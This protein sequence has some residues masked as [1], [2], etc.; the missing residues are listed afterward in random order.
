MAGRTGKVAG[1]LSAVKVAGAK[2]AGLYGDGNGL[3]LKV[4]PGG[5]KSWVLRYKIRGRPRKY[6]LGP[7]H[8]V[9]LALARQKAGDAR[10]LLL[11]GIDPIEQRRTTKGAAA[12]QAAKT[13]TFDDCS[14]RYI[15]ANKVAWKNPKHISEWSKT[16]QRYASPVFGHL[17]VADVDVGLVVRALEKI[18]TTKPET[19]GR[20][21]GRIET[22]LDYA[23]AHSY[24]AGE[25]PARM[26]GN[27]D[28]ILP[29]HSKLKVVVHH[30][31]MPHAEVAAL[32]AKLATRHEISAA[33][34][35]FTILTAARTG[36]I[37]GAQ[38]DEVDLGAK[39]WTVPGRRMKSG[40]T[41]TVPLSDAALT[42]LTKVRAEHGAGGYVFA[43]EKSGKAMAVS[44]MAVCLRRLGAH[45]HATVHGFRSSFRD[46]AAEQTAT[47]REVVEA[48]LAHA[49]GD[50]VEAAYLRT[51]HLEKRRKLMAAW[52]RYISA[53]APANAGKGKVVAIGRGR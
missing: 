39:T 28:H 33:A 23:K 22:V 7:L 48:C 27:L 14:K 25:N 5:S 11:D 16:L 26:K 38:W 41:H 20:V 42:V 1:K 34:L 44:S 6:G 4:D 32:M 17:A 13:I 3:Y 2:E 35:A 46:W 9:G 19:A 47:P 52:A 37:I 24:R 43:G 30:P 49:L 40:K 21:R 8:T 29:P 31:A 53:P 15:A 45:D 12:L 18:W 10:R 51:E 36:E 50:K